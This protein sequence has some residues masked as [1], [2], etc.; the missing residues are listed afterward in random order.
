ML[1]FILK[2]PHLSQYYLLLQDPEQGTQLYDLVADLHGQESACKDKKEKVNN[3]VDSLVKLF[4]EEIQKNKKIDGLIENCREDK[5]NLSL[6][7]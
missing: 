4:D 6:V 1:Y 2:T 5:I 7:V 3:L